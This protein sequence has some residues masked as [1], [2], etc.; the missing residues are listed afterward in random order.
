MAPL[1]EKY[2]NVQFD[3]EM[4]GCVVLLITIKP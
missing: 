4:E 2:S 3:F 1:K